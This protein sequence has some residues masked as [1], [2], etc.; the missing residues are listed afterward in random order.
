M[1]LEIAPN[2]TNYTM[3]ID[4]NGDDKIDEQKNPDMNEVIIVTPEEENIFDTSSGTYPS[5]MGTHTGTI[6]P[7][8]TITVSKLYTYPCDGTGGH[9][10]YVAIFSLNGTAIAEAHWNGYVNDWYNLT[11]NTSF[12]LYANETYNYIIRT[13]SYPQIIHEKEFNA[14]GGK[15]TCT[16][17]VDTNGKRYTDWIP[18]IRLE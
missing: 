3:N 17:F 2:V 11:F 12:T 16:E 1:S 5:V 15:I 8:K 14:T 6:K 7:N 9:T 18:A 13:G 4:Y 10:K